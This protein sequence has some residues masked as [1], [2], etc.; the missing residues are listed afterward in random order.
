MKPS[1][2]GFA[3]DPKLRE[4]PGIKLWF[5][6]VVVKLLNDVLAPVDGAAIQLKLPEVSLDSMYPLLAAAAEG[7]VSV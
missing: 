2:H 6:D 7:H 5:I 1:V 3:A 4:L